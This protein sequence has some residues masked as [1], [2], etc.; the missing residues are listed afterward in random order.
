MHLYIILNPLLFGKK[1]VFFSFFLHNSCLPFTVFSTNNF[2]SSAAFDIVCH[3]ISL[4][5]LCICIMS[6]TGNVLS[7]LATYGFW[8]NQCP[9]FRIVY[10]RALQG[11]PTM[12]RLYVS[13]ARQFAD[14]GT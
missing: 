6:K 1:R 11:T 7:R 13:L 10:L 5:V 12:Q 2:L 4:L 8:K 9:A 14:I 3:E